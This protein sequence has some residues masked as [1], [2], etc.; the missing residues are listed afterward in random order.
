MKP[1]GFWSVR[2]ILT[3]LLAIAGVGVLIRLGIWQLDRLAQ[4]RVFNERVT[5]QLQAS[6]LDLTQNV[7][8]GR[9]LYDMEYRSVVV[10]GEYDFSQEVLLRNQDYGGQLGF[11]V[12]TPLR[13]AN[14]D[15][16][17]LV[18][19]GWIPFDQAAPE[20]RAQFQEPG[21][22]V[23]RGVIRRPQTHPDF[24]GVPDPTLAPGETRLD[25]WNI[26][27]L[28]RIRL[29]VAEPLLPVYIVQ[30]PDPSWSGVPV[31]QMVMPEI[32]EGPHMG[33]AMQWFTF[34]ATLGLGYP[35]FVRKQLMRSTK[36]AEN[37]VAGNE[38]I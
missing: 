13:I 26:V 38:S 35:F 9:Q 1:V 34:A 21:Q 2:W 37:R 31:R 30:G 12:L 5:A 11:H 4:R 10:R 23:V 18:D 16:S 14:S 6:E 29:Q 8:L 27:N 22:V 20:L 7:D 15:Q 24:G 3:T 19:R 25:A 33:Y 32:S 17:V 36:L 28:D